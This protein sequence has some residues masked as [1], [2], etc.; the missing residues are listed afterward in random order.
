M[1]SVLTVIIYGCS[2]TTNSNPTPSS[3]HTLKVGDSLIYHYYRTDSTGTTVAGS[4]STLVGS[5]QAILASYLGKSNVYFIKVGIDTAYYSPSND[6]TW[7]IIQPSVSL[8]FG[9][10]VPEVWIPY[11][12][13]SG[14]VTV[15]DSTMSAVYNGN[16]DTART[17]YTITYLGHGSFTFGGSMLTT[18]K[19]SRV[20]T[21][22]VKIAKKTYTTTHTITQ[23]FAPTI[24]FIVSRTEQTVSN[25]PTVIQGTTYRTLTGTSFH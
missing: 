8:N 25:A 1:A 19:Y 21:T 7:S 2:S 13:A 5:V 11:N 23:E 4:D 14:S 12:P 6:S 3:S 24:G 17:T 20:N 9:P 16:N 22:V 18:Y 10:T 15:Y